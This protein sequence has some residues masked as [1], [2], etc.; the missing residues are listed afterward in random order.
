MARR[1]RIRFRGA[2]YHAMTRGVR[3]STLFVDDVDRRKFLRILATAVE[4]YG[5]FC[6]TYCLMGNH[7]HLVIQTPRKN[8]SRFMQYLDGVYGKYF[9]WRHKYRGHVYEGRFSAPVIE[10]SLYLARAIAYIGRNPVEAM[11]VKDAADWKWSS[12]RAAVGKC[13][14]PGFLTL[15]WLPRLFEA[16]TLKESRR[17]F[18]IA[19]H[20]SD[21]CSDI[22]VG[23]VHGSSEFRR[24]VR[25]VIGA[26][27]YKMELP[28][29]YRAIAQPPLDELFAGVK[30][31]QRR[32]AILRAHVIHGYLLSEIARYLDLHPTT[33][34]R[35]VN[36]TGTYR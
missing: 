32:A 3:K 17:L 7:F 6:F 36:R 29:S 25:K 33:V 20:A 27:L 10:D 34:S 21:R 13:V 12:Y 18:S 16:S 8:I 19:V 4:R 30:K 24:K 1:P 22:E 15:D 14:C 2:I 35:I 11:L 31:S 26:T 5:C 23:D 9:N 28:R